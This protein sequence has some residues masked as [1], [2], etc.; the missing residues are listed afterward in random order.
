MLDGLWSDLRYRLRAVFRRDTVERELDDELRFHLDQE[1]EKYIAHGMSRD[2]ALR[3][4]RLAFGGVDRFKEESRDARG[5]R[6]LEDVMA[7]V[8]FTVRTL[9]KRPA[10]TIV[11]VLTLMLGIGA[12]TAIFSVVSAVLLRPL[13]YHDPARL[14]MVWGVQGS[15][16]MQGVTYPDYLDWRARNHVFEDI[17][18]FRGQSVNLTGEEQPD[19][20]IGSFISASF[21]RLLGA[22]AERGR[23]FSDAET[24][25]GTA[26]PVAVISDEAW[27]TRFGSDPKVLG[28]T[29]VLNGQPFTVVGITRR[30][31]EEPLGTP[32]VWLPI[33]YYPNAGGLQR[34]TRG[35]LA[36]AR[37]APGVGLARAQ[38]EMDAIERRLA[39]EYP[40][41][42][43][44]SGVRLAPLR[45]E[46]VG[47][48][49]APLYTLLGAVGVVLLIACANV[50]N[51][52]LARA[53]ARRREISVRAALGAARARLVR[54]L[55]TESV[56]LAVIGGAAGIALGWLGVR[57]LAPVVS[58]VG[59]PLVG[60]VSL[61]GTV[62]AFAVG[63]TMVTGVIFGLVPA[64]HASRV[65]LAHALGERVGSG[66]RSRM[67]ARD[68][69]VVAQ[70]A[71]CIVLL[72]GAGLL[73]RSLVSLQHVDAGFD[74]ARLLTMELRLPPTKYRDDA[75]ITRMFDAMIARIRAVPGVRAA[76]LVR[77]VPMSGNADG[78]VYEIEGRPAP[79]PAR[80][81]ETQ[82]N[83]VSPGYFA[84][85][86]IPILRGR[87]FTE[88]DRDG[89]MRVVIV[90][91]RMAAREWPGESPIGKRIRA[92]GTDAWLTVVG[93]VG[94]TK[95]FALDDRPAEQAY[96]PYMQAPQIFTSVVART[97]GDPMAL[98]A[99]VRG[100]IWRVD[101]DQP[102]WKIRSMELLMRRSLRQRRVVMA[103][104]GTFAAV[105]LL[106]AAVGIY[107]VVSYLVTRR[108]QEVGIRM[109]LGARATDVR[110][111]VVWQGLRVVGAA[112]LLGVAVALVASRLITSQLYGVSAAD[113][114]TF[115]AAPLVLVLVALAALYL[116]ARRASRVDPVVALRAE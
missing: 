13:P 60:A 57:A 47:P 106:L 102:V 82:L 50:A 69:L 4:A 22:S 108:T 68:A 56:L 8:A 9:V 116:P 12:N 44:G 52:Q 83:T 3:R 64:L 88:R 98:G 58:D 40:E 6:L 91:D 27:R 89:A 26:Q 7:D 21:F 87:D 79:D 112:V 59:L 29:L 38:A 15:D 30:D 72:V 41:T 5:T 85:M 63:L 65:D 19:R 55:L 2:D 33:A 39:E 16:A 20:M 18:V 43:A 105:A 109:A 94:S 66:G 81:A 37:L 49:R 99:A 100:A 24:A 95:H 71:L 96:I 62:L 70:M 74:P 67:A 86:R 76:A 97:A 75:S 14:V 73:T 101:R 80:A 42:N 114:V 10:F 51:L 113:P 78:A 104:T 25:V 1:A 53:A 23:L 54:Q 77:A 48:A 93:V 103:L 35:M 17:G 61:D 36:L 90:N 84:T 11:A 115:V 28:R 110:R 92:V 107:G 111:M 34:G 45:D 46:L 32:D 31:Y